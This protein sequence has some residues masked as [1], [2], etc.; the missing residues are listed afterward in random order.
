MGVV[1]ALDDHYFLGD[2][3]PLLFGH[4]LDLDHLDGEAF[5][6]SLFTT[7]EDLAGGP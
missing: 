7:L 3:F 1:D 2:H 5:D 6:L 4:R